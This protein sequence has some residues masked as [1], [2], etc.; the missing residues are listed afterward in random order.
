MAS[1]QSVD[2]ANKDSTKRTDAV[3]SFLGQIQLGK[4]SLDS[5]R[6]SLLV[7]KPGEGV[8]EVGKASERH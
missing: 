5:L 4:Q 7:K 6:R 3:N 1:F 2:E 8:Q